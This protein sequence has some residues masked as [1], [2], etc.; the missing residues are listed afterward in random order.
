MRP[1]KNGHYALGCANVEVASLLGQFVAE[2]TH[3]EDAMASV[4]AVLMGDLDDITARYIFRSIVAQQGRI[5]AM[6]VLL[7]N[8]PT[9]REIS[10]RTYDDF[11]AE[12]DALNA[13]RNDYVHGLWTTDM[14]DDKAYLSPASADR[15][16][17]F[18]DSRQVTPKELKGVID[19]LRTLQLEGRLRAL[20]D[21]ETR[22]KQLLERTQKPA[23]TSSPPPSTRRI[24]ASK[25][26]RQRK[27][28]GG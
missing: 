27:T 17:I 22:R 7:E 13:V 23:E 3:L 19:R 9:N 28:T 16:A 5:K 4:F 18:G 24:A 12:F 11:I 6:T 2:F 8:C 25:R 15:F 14:A 10:D 20:G 26:L 21:L 1:G